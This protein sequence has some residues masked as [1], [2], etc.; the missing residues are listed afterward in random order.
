MRHYHRKDWQK[1][2]KEVIELDGNVCVRCKRGPLQGAVLQVHH[3]EYLL[4]KL[5]WEYPYEL[6]ETLCKGCHAGEHGI[7]M[8]FRGWVCIGY[9]DLGEPT[10]ECEVCGKSIRYVFFVQHDKWPSLEVG[11]TC[12]DHLTD[13]TAAGDH[14]DSVRRLESRKK[15]FIESTRWKPDDNGA[16]RIHQ[17]GA[18][19]VIEPVDHNYRLIANNTKGRRRFPTI[20]DAKAFAFDLLENG[21]L[22][23]FLARQKHKI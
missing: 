13:T 7:I 23:A 11:E 4:G 17:K 10:G 16:W 15:R 3:K 5:P 20:L 22:E 12:C 2:R 9:D 19:L 14:M 1:Y 8:P 6:C 18:T 21:K